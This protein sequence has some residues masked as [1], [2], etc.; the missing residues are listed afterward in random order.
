MMKYV[1]SVFFVVLAVGNI[2]KFSQQKKY[3]HQQLV[4]WNKK[5]IFVNNP[6]LNVRD[7]CYQSADFFRMHNTG[8]SPCEKVT[9][10]SYKH[11]A[12]KED[13][14]LKRK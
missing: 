11:Y 6:T 14:Y 7:E 9:D 5:V 12:T 1:I 3:W 4:N 10:F 2:W 8:S 13:Y